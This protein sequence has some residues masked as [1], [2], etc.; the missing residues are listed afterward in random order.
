MAKVSTVQ[1]IKAAP[2]KAFN[3]RRNQRPPPNAG[4]SPRAFLAEDLLKFANVHKG[5]PIELAKRFALNTS[6]VSTRSDD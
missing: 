5:V 1:L 3:G 4:G 6:P 2:L